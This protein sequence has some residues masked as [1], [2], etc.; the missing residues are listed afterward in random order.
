MSN[1]RATA[2]AHPRIAALALFV[3]LAVPFAAFGVGEIINK[4]FVQ[5]V[6]TFR[7]NAEQI[8]NNTDDMI[9]FQGTGGTDNTDLRV[10]LDGTQPVLDSPTDTAVGIDDD[11]QFVGAQTIST[12]AG[13]LTIAPA[14]GLV[15]SMDATSGFIVQNNA[16]GSVLMSLRDYADSADDDM[17]HTLFTTNCTDAGSGTEDCDFFIGVAEA[18]AAPETRFAIDADGDITIGSANN[19]GVLLLS[20]NAVGAQVRNAATGNVDL[21]FRDY[22]DSADDDMAHTL[23]R[24]NCTD[25]TTGAEDCDFSISVPE[26]GA[27]V[28]ARLTID[29]DAGITLGGATNGNIALLCD[30][31]NGVE[32]RNGVTGSVLWSMRDYADTTDDDQAHTL[33][34][35]NCTDTGTGAEDCDFSIG[36][37]EAG[38]AP[39]TRLNF[40]ADGVITLGGTNAANVN[41]QPDDE[42]VIENA[43]T[44]NVVLSLSDFADSADDDMAH[45]QVLVNCT[46]AASGTE[47]CDLSVGI[48]EAGAAA[49]TRLFFDADGDNRIGSANSGGFIVLAD[50]TTGLDVRN[51]ATGSVIQSY[52]DYADTADDD[53]AHAQV[54]VNC[55]DVGT[56]AEDCDY[57]VGV[58]EAGAAAEARIGCDA[59]D[60]CFLGSVNT[61][62]IDLLTDGTGTAEVAMPA[63]AVDSAE[64]LDGELVAADLADTLCL[65]V[66]SVTFNPTEAGATNDLVSLHSI[67]VANGDARFSATENDQDDFRVP[68]AVT[69]DSL[70]VIVDVAPGAGN[71]DWKV[72]LR[73]DGA[74]TALTCSV[75]EGA[76]TCADA[77]APVAVAALS[78][79]NVLV[80][81]SGGGADP[82]AAAEMTISF[83]LGQ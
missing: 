50:A 12:S 34:T 41:L 78:R 11:L 75:D 51:N 58:V 79:L 53:M 5:G 83:C 76:T 2:K 8:D 43:A 16:T 15:M 18:G 29:A 33:F 36:I 37:T 42:V 24:T 81:S 54:V 35:T 39:E 60:E 13:A 71:D 49:E 69:L 82:T 10:D 23:L 46:D 80:D 26:A 31:T 3:L 63:G 73:D 68:V 19:G 45:G 25:A 21:S 74:S 32:V 67:D 30:A 14:A 9:E 72:T 61:A 57:S 65:Q 28:E 4:P 70:A 38:A 48:V 1:L 6:L 66:I 56:G 77:V 44:G 64:V 7:G 59:D 52:R 47:D 40:D 22:A 17:A 62:R 55:T 27:A 20:S